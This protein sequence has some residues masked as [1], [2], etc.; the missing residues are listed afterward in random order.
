MCKRGQLAPNK[1]TSGVSWVIAHV[2]AQII[3]YIDYQLSDNFV[4]EKIQTSQSS[5]CPQKNGGRTGLLR[6]FGQYVHTSLAHLRDKLLNKY[7]FSSLA[8]SL[9]NILVIDLFQSRR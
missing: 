7:S 6:L 3:R 2:S 9:L 8:G 1:E 5:Y 4:E